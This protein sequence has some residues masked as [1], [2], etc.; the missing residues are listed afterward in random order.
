LV[1]SYRI[2][3]QRPQEIIPTLKAPRAPDPLRVRNTLCTR[4]MALVPLATRRDLF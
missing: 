1:G 4:V 2:D 3:E